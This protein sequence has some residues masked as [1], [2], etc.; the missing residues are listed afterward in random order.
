[1]AERLPRARPRI[2]A[3]TEALTSDRPVKAQAAQPKPAPE[4]GIVPMDP[5][6]WEA[7]F[8]NFLE[9]VMA[10]ASIGGDPEPLKKELEW[11]TKVAPPDKRAELEKNRA[12][13]S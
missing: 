9:R 13:T 1:M 3:I 7:K 10:T 6:E 8:A 11:L 12:P 2:D 5:K 4:P